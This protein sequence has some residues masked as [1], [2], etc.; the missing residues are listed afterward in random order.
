[1]S[2]V[3]SSRREPKSAHSPAPS[4][5]R[6]GRTCF[7]RYHPFG[8]SP[9][10]QAGSMLTQRRIAAVG[11]WPSSL[12]SKVSRRQGAALLEPMPGTA[13]RIGADTQCRSYFTPRQVTPSKTD[14]VPLEF[15]AELGRSNLHGI[16]QI[17]PDFSIASCKRRILL[18]VV[19]KPLRAGHILVAPHLGG[20]PAERNAPQKFLEILAR[21]FL[22]PAM[23][24]EKLAQAI[25]TNSLSR[26][27]SSPPCLEQLSNVTG[28]R[29]RRQLSDPSQC[30]HA[31]RGM[32]PEGFARQAVCPRN[33]KHF[34]IIIGR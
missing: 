9:F 22:F 18:Q 17:V 10:D 33:T 16:G 4:A 14:H 6:C 3:P 11:H 28:R 2:A 7:G 34:P 32:L 19:M 1:M 26:R 31:P 24:L 13:C 12:M 29:S 21:P 15:L 30:L 23:Q 20:V 27:S 8:C 25:V 5:R